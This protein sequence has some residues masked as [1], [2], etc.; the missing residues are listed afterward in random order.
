[1]QWR[2]DGW[3]WDAE[4]PERESRISATVSSDQSLVQV[5][6]WEGYVCVGVMTTKVERA[7][8]FMQLSCHPWWLEKG[9]AQFGLSFYFKQLSMSLMS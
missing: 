3:I 2:G 5:E 4:C 6:I 1:M 8:P 9:L 7:G